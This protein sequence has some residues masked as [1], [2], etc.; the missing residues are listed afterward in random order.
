MIYTSYYGNVKNLPE[1]SIL[2]SISV[3]QPYYIEKV[4]PQFKPWWETVNNIKKG[5]IDET[6]YT[7]QYLSKISKYNDKTW[8]VIKKMYESEK[9][10]ILLCYEKPEDFCH[11]HILSKFLNEKLN[12]NIQEWSKTS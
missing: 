9:N 7:R 2:V 4:I 8:N 11:R 1:D 6:E 10:Y 3:T 5:I 12:I